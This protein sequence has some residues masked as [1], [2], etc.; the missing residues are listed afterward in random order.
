MLLVDDARVPSLRVAWQTRDGWTNCRTQLRYASAV[1]RERL[2]DNLDAYV[3]LGGSRLEK[4]A[5][6][7]TGAIVRV[8]FYKRDA[9]RLLMTDAAEG[10]M[11]RV[12]LTGV[13]FNQPVETQS[14]SVL[15]H[16]KYSDGALEA[17]GAPPRLADLFLTADARD[18]LSSRIGDPRAVRAGF[19]RPTSD[20]D[21]PDR[22]ARPLPPEADASAQVAT[23]VLDDG[24]VELDVLFPYSAFRHVVAALQPPVPGGFSEPDHFHIEFQVVPATRAGDAT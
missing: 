12:T 5:A 2:C 17:C 24:S 18:D 1:A 14:R 16:L 8:G 10:A 22:L 4:G 3:A 9:E 21:Q 19:F 7:P 13:H 11:I 15:T 23:R 20:V 6:D